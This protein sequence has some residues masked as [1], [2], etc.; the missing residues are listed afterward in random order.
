MSLSDY[1]VIVTGGPTREWI[2]PVRYISN[3]SSGKMGIAIADEAQKRKCK[4][5]FI[6]GPINNDLLKGKSFEIVPIET[7]NDLLEEVLNNIQEKS[8][9]IMAAAPADYKP[10]SKA[11]QKI[12]KNDSELIIKMEKNPDVLKNVASKIEKNSIENIFV[13]DFAAETNDVE[14]HARTKLDAKKL[15]MI[16]LNDVTRKGARFGSDTNIITIFKKEIVLGHF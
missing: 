9:L 2:D 8:V 3:P 10:V 13:V 6:H 15:N 14:K 1:K 11:E 7:T 16:C 5:V 12:K 4:T